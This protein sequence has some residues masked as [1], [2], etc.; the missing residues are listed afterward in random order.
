MIP[1]PSLTSDPDKRLRAE[2]A[3]LVHGIAPWDELER[4]HLKAAAEWI[5]GGA[6]LY[7]TR[8]PDVP[9]THLVSYFVVLDERR[10]ELLLVAHR[11]A[12][13]WLPPGG[14]VEPDERPWAAVVRECREELGIAAVAAPVA[15]ERPFFLTVTRTRG[16]G[17]HTDVSLWYVLSTD[18]GSI[19][20]YD[21]EEFSAIRWLSV[22]QVL[23]EPLDV[24]DPHM[25][26]FAHK[27]RQAWSE[28]RGQPGPAVAAE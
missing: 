9:A 1:S 2:L 18:A 21:E 17:E 22:E 25:H 6:P 23:D 12:G 10:G 7:R 14:H 15:G 27:L 13:L 8:K 3:E 19:T 11:K 20:S 5:A 16:Q 24:L 28:D 26:R 4:T